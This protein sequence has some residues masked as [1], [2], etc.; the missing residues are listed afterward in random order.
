[1]P[2]SWTTRRCWTSFPSIPHHWPSCLGLLEIV[3]QK[4][5]S[6]PRNIQYEVY[7]LDYRPCPEDGTLVLWFWTKSGQ[8][9][10]SLP[11]VGDSNPTWQENKER[12]E[13]A[14]IALHPQGKGMGQ[15]LFCDCPEMQIL[16]ERTA[17]Y[18]K[19]TLF[20]SYL[21]FIWCH[22]MVHQFLHG[23]NS[24]WPYLGT[25]ISWFNSE[26]GW[27]DS[28]VVSRILF[29]KGHLVLALFRCLS[30]Y[31]NNADHRN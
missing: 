30:W 19:P 27:L 24:H 20:F 21:C 17:Q 8:L 10:Q 16:K 29:W 31:D 26:L 11:F 5:H 23:W 18:P 15:C 2:K 22:P 13:P 25:K 12:A 7:C 4:V 3:V 14:E 28:P 9:P 6:T 1:M